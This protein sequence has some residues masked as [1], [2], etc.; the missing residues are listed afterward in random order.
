M[1]DPPELIGH[2]EDITVLE[3]S[4]DIEIQLSEIFYDVEN[5]STLA[6][7]ISENI[8]AMTTNIADTV[9]IL[10]LI[11]EVYGSGT[12]EI[13]ASDNISRFTVNTSFNVV[14]LPVNNPPLIDYVYVELDEDSE[15]EIILS[16]QD[17]EGDILSYL[18]VNN[19]I[20][21]S[22]LHEGENIYVYL[23]DSDYF[24]LDSL[25]YV[26][27]EVYLFLMEAISL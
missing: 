4:E 7:S 21:G 18:I 6:Y 23:P 3:N 24:G 22:L 20:H 11:E 8:D 5:G 13:T 2:I 17:P 15:I 14:I 12:V 9:L 10:S 27:S 1:N 26:V 19:P 16:A 25:F